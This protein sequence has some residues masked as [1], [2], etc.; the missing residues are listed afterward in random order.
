MRAADPKNDGEEVTRMCGA[1]RACTDGTTGLSAGKSADRGRDGPRC[2]TRDVVRS[3]LD[4]GQSMLV[5]G[6]R[7]ARVLLQ[8]RHAVPRLEQRGIGLEGLLVGLPCGLDL[9][10]GQERGGNPC[11]ANRGAWEPERPGARVRAALLGFSQ[12]KPQ[13]RRAIH[14][15][16]R[17]LLGRIGGL[18]DLGRRRR[19]ALEQDSRSR[20]DRA[21]PGS[22]RWPAAPSGA[23]R[24]AELASPPPGPGRRADGD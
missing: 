3:R 14:H 5:R 20:S 1:V 8:D 18:E 12:M 19:T 11:I 24:E 21:L 2:Q 17:G 4:R 6:R 15:V 16:P 10:F 7:P 13:G 22:S 9:S 23:S